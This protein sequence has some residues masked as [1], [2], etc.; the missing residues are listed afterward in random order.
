MVSPPNG[1]KESA[2]LIRFA[3]DVRV[4]ERSAADLDYMYADLLE[5]DQPGQ[6]DAALENDLLGRRV[7][8]LFANG[9]LAGPVTAN[10]REL[11]SLTYDVTEDSRSTM[12]TVGVY[13]AALGM[14]VVI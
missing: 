13:L 9:Q 12:E 7:A 2:S 14:R 1:K 6:A 11:R 10:G 5:S 4:G 8:E 3:T